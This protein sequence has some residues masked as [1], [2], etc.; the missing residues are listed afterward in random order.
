MNEFKDYLNNKTIVNFVKSYKENFYRKII[1][2]M[3]NLLI[4]YFNYLIFLEKEEQEKSSE[5]DIQLILESPET[6]G[7]TYENYLLVK[8]SK[9]FI[10]CCN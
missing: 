6:F 9:L 3:G 4:F 10:F 1:A 7:I 8:K 5:E 2:F